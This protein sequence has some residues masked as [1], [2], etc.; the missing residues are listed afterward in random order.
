MVKQFQERL[1]EVLER[2]EVRSS[3]LGSFLKADISL[4]KLAS[5]LRTY[6]VLPFIK[7]M[8]EEYALSLDAG[9]A[10]WPSTSPGL[11]IVGQS[12]LN[13]DHKQTHMMEKETH[14]ALR[15]KVRLILRIIEKEERDR[16][17]EL[18]PANQTASRL[19]QHSQELEKERK[20]SQSDEPQDSQAS[21][22]TGDHDNM[23]QDAVEML[24]DMLMA[25]LSK[26]AIFGPNTLTQSKSSLSSSLPSYSSVNNI[27]G[28]RTNHLSGNTSGKQASNHVRPTP[29]QLNLEKPLPPIVDTSGPWKYTGYISQTR[30]VERKSSISL[31]WPFSDVDHII[32]ITEFYFPI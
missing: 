12:N 16:Q 4:K 21:K 26:V 27:R 29:G 14:D 13:P 6:S 20:I 18:A 23:E 30:K 5:L 22:I 19:N 8:I 7:K 28:Q 24:Y 17:D 3:V 2:F 1:S 15:I 32:L 9:A 10:R 25:R 11:A 31:P